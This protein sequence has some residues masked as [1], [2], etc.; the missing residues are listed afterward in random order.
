MKVG[1]NASFLRKPDTGI[2]QVT[3][4]FLKKLKEFPISNF[5]FPTEFILYLEKD[6]DLDLPEN[7][8]KRILESKFY[9]RDDLARKIIWEKYL[10]PKQIEKDG[11]DVLLS[12]YQS[13][14][15]SKIKHLMFV[16]DTV[17]KIF[18]QYLNNWRKKIY[19]RMIDQ[20]IPKADKV[21]T[22]SENSKQDIVKYF[23]IPDD[24]IIVSYIDC[25][26]VFK[27]Q[28]S[29]IKNKEEDPDKQKENTNYIF[30]VGG[31]DVRKNIDGLLESYGLLWKKWPLDRKRF[32][33]LVLAGEFCSQ[34]VPLVTDIPNKI[35]QVSTKYKLDKKKIKNVGFVGQE[36]LPGLY[37]NAVLF[38]YPSLYEGFGLPPLEAQNCGCPVIALNNSSL[39]EVLKDQSA[40]L[41]DSVKPEAIAQAMVKVLTDKK[42]R[43]NLIQKG[44]ENANRFS[45]YKFTENILA[46][47]V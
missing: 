32:P 19:Y 24:K 18:P 13:A 14:T 27:N 23:K 17:W 37:K 35:E 40:F 34:L 25:D 12:P 42:L 46:E 30:Y 41:V 22:I 15:I 7:F 38:C 2:G 26:E 43:A 29:G 33:D 36:D 21:V 10:L 39:P 9:R 28:E 3:F 5:Q 45:W 20:A 31:F 16:H 8:K 1:I 11:C 44:Y 6:V 47:I 4:N